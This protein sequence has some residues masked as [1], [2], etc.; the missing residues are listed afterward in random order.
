ML[1]NLFVILPFNAL[2][3]KIPLFLCYFSSNLILS[4]GRKAEKKIRKETSIRLL[5]KIL[6]LS[7]P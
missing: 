6:Y 7:V 4:T 3:F 1:T 2:Q 5:T